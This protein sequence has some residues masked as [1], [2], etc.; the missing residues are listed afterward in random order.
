MGADGDGDV[1]AGEAMS[2]S[3]GLE[4]CTGDETSVVDAED[5]S[6]TGMTGEIVLAWRRGTP[7]PAP[8]PVPDMLGG[9]RDGSS[10][11]VR[12]S[13]RSSDDDERRNEST[14]RV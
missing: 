12:A 14:E 11:S 8:A 1:F 10:D 13:A 5:A 2:R 9:A 6:P 4:G 3:S 7:L